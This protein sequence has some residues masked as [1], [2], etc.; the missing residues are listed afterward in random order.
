MNARHTFPST[1]DLIAARDEAEA[2]PKLLRGSGLGKS[3]AGPRYYEVERNFYAE[4][5]WTC[6]TFGTGHWCQGTGVPARYPT[7]EAAHEAGRKWVATGGDRS[8]RERRA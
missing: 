2:L 8:V 3:F 7:E 4:N 6:R 1:P 5:T